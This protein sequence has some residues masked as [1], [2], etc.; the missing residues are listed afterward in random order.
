MSRQEILQKE[1]ILRNFLDQN[2]LDGILLSRSASFAWLTGGGEDF[3]NKSAL[4]GV[5]DILFV[6]DHKYLIASTIEQYRV[7]E[8]EVANQGFE[9]II[10]N[11]YEGKDD[12]I[13]KLT[14]GKKIGCDI[15][16]SNFENV[17]EKLKPLRYSLLPEEVERFENIGAFAAKCMYETALEI[18]PGLTENDVAGMLAYKLVSAGYQVP[19]L[20]VASDERIY[21]YRHPIPKDK[22]IEKYVLIAVGAKRWGLAASMT[23][24]IHFCP[25]PEDLR[26]KMNAVAAVDAEL[27]SS[28]V[29]GADV[30]SILQRAI[31]TYEDKGYPDEWRLHHQ[32][33][34][35]GYDNRDYLATPRTK[36]NVVVNQ[37]FAWNPSITGVKSEDTIITTANGIKCITQIDDWP[38]IDVKANGKIISRPD[39]L[40]R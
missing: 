12:T 5:V 35:A 17:Y 22:V 4:T 31:R 6:K 39:I 37:G 1:K 25:L 33:G 10:Y 14:A 20:L 29:P 18:K 3:V 38:M 9:L 8:E 16:Y 2:N 11:W 30:A 32:G 13:A 34:A 28:T 21:R 7:P 40:V 26:D 27:I 19:V 15:D 36:E 23:R 24:L